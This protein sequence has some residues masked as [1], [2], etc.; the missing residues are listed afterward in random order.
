MA[1]RFYDDNQILS[2]SMR[3]IYTGEDISSDFFDD[4]CGKEKYNECLDAYKVDD[5]DYLV[6]YV[7]SYLNGT[8]KDV[9]YPEDYDPEDP[10]YELTYDIEDRPA[11]DP[12]ALES[13]AAS[14]YAGGWS[15]EDR[16]AIQREYDLTDDETDAIVE[17]L[18]EYEN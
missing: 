13:G 16:D 2:I 7:E 3:S 5:V 14:L 11:A 10:D 1:T 18:A 6:D 17:K 4:A 9:D 12:V 15:A 8:N